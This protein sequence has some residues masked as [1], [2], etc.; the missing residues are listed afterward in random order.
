MGTRRNGIVHGGSASSTEGIPV[1]GEQKLIERVAGGD[2]N[3]IWVLVGRYQGLLHRHCRKYFNGDPHD[4]DDALS[5]IN[6]RLYAELPQRVAHIKN[7]DA[8]LTRVACN[9]CLDIHRQR[10]SELERGARLNQEPCQQENIQVNP[11]SE[12]LDSELIH[13]MLQELN[14]LPVT[15]QEVA[16]MRFL[17]EDTYENIARQQCISQANARKRIQAARACLKPVLQVYLEEN[18]GHFAQ[19]CTGW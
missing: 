15:L 3:A 18:K 12:L 6:L 8:W 5:V 14:K 11:E 13:F 10:R 17:Q 19:N 7:L 1:S 2:K 4:A 16:M 9:L